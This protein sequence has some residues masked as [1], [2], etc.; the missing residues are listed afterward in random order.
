MKSFEIGREAVNISVNYKNSKVEWPGES[1]ATWLNGTADI[2]CSS[3]RGNIKIKVGCWLD[4]DDDD[5]LWNSSHEGGRVLK[6]IITGKPEEFSEE[7]F[8]PNLFPEITEEIGG[9]ICKELREQYWN[10]RYE[11]DAEEEEIGGYQYESLSKQVKNKIKKGRGILNEDYDEDGIDGL[12]E[13]EDTGKYRAYDE[14]TGW[15]GRVRT[16][17]EKADADAKT[18]NA[19]CAKQGGYCSAI[20]VTDDGYGRCMDLDGDYVWPSYGRGSGAVRW[21]Y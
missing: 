16:S 6:S 4:T 9:Y 2:R 19:E 17:P 21:R 14:V 3:L 18:H 20:V 12:K 15:M 11:S 7:P 10:E 13:M 5:Q 8:I 1:D